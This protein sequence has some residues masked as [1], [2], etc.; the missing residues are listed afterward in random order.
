MGVV[1]MAMRCSNCGAVN[2]E[3]KKFCSDC[4]SMI[5]LSPQS[6]VQYA[7]VQQKQ[8]YQ[9]RVNVFCLL[10][11]VIAVISLFLPWAM[12]EDKESGDTAN[13]GAFDFNETFWG[14]DVFPSN[15][16]YSVTLFLIGTAIAFFCPLGGILQIIGSMGFIISTLTV[17]FE[18]FNIVFW[19]G[20]L[21]ALVSAV[22]VLLSLVYP[23]GVGYEPGKRDALARL[24]TVSVYR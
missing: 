6:P 4:G 22:F 20:S 8:P 3:G 18:T 17:T 15:F 14:F 10:G 7:P 23:L 5:V 24:L 16:H 2:P 1:E 19:I 9:L 11:A 21:A 12:V 13:L